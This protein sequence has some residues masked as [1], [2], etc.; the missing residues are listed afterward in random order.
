[1]ACLTGTIPLATSSGRRRAMTPSAELAPLSASSSL[2]TRRSLSATTASLTSK[3]QR[4]NDKG[5]RPNDKGQRPKRKDKTMKSR[6]AQ[7]PQKP[8][9]KLFFVFHPSSH[10][11]FLASSLPRIFASSHLRFHASSSI[12]VTHQPQTLF[13]Y[14]LVEDTQTT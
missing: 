12:W 3:G 11:R 6:K 8:T 1:M 13:L 7:N 5:Q 2:A 10:L 14:L 4:P 9:K